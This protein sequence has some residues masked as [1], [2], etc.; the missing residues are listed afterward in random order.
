MKKLLLV[1]FLISVITMTAFGVGG[2]YTTND[3]FYLPAYGAYGT[4]EYNEYNTYMEIADNAIKANTDK[5]LSL[6]YLKTAIDTQGEVETIWGVTL[7]TDTER[8]ILT[9]LTNAVDSPCVVTGGVVSEGTDTGTF[10]VTAI[11]EA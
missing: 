3:M 7:S 10:K 1:L 5:D 4:D 8:N 2:T 6:Y 11:T 9:N